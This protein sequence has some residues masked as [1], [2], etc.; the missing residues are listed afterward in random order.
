MIWEKHRVQLIKCESQDLISPLISPVWKKVNL[1]KKKN[2]YE[3]EVC[4]NA[5]MV[6]LVW[7][8]GQLQKF[9]VMNILG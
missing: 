8:Y 3:V 1:I 5:F 2:K 7:C 4:V 9:T 6:R